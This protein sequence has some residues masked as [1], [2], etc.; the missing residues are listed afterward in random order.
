MLI[1]M[2]LF[3]KEGKTTNKS[4]HISEDGMLDE[5]WGQ[6]FSLIYFFLRKIRMRSCSASHKNCILV[7]EF[8]EIF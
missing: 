7:A 4:P 5:L 8:N 3:N 6:A 1:R 2:R